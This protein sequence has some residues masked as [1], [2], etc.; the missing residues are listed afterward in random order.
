MKSAASPVT[1]RV[2]RFRVSPAQLSRK[3]RFASLR[4]ALIIHGVTHLRVVYCALAGARLVTLCAIPRTL[5]AQPVSL[6][7][8]LTS[9]LLRAFLRWMALTY[10]QWLEGEESVGTLDWGMETS[11]FTHRHGGY[12]STYFSEHRRG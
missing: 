9:I 8:P 6:P 11:E 1:S 2:D 3:A 4:H 12:Q 5:N 7:A 10:P